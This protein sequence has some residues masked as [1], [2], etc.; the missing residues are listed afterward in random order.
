[1]AETKNEFDQLFKVIEVEG[2]GGTL[3]YRIEMEIRIN[4]E[5]RHAICLVDIPDREQAYAFVDRLNGH[6]RYNS[7]SNY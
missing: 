3:L 5:L 4:G 7:N 1:M 6:Y 2:V